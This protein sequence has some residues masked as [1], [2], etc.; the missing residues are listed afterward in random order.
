MAEAHVKYATASDGVGIA[1]ADTGG[2][3]TPVLYMRGSPFTHV[4]L[5][6][7][8]TSYGFWFENLFPRRRLITFDCRGCGL[9][10]RNVEEMSVEVFCR[11]IAAVADKLGLE[12]FALIA[13]YS[14]GIAATAYAA[15]NP[16]RVSHLILWDAYADGGRFAEIPQ[17]KA[18]LSMMENDWNLFATT[19]G[20]FMNDWDS[21]AAREYVEFLQEASTQKEALAFFQNYV[22]KSDTSDDLSRITQPALVLSHKNIEI[23]DFDMARSLASS[24]PNAEL[25]VLEG[26]WGKPGED[27]PLVEDALNRLLGD[28]PAATETE[29]AAPAIGS[30]VTILFTDIEGSTALTQKL[31]DAGARELFR[32]HERITREAL[33]AHGGAEVKTMGDGFM[34]SFGSAAGA[35]ECAIAIQQALADGQVKVRI[36][37]NAGEPIAEENPDGRGDLFGTSVI[38]AA[39]IAAQASGGEILASNVVRELVAGRLPL[40][41]QG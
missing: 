13:A 41:G 15:D 14:D 34:V 29:P 7:K 5:E 18:F 24:L 33:A 1:F 8:Q 17:T 21:D 27:P 40:L 36:G 9:S 39:R 6:W 35:I 38:L 12:R 2:D 30:L 31:G 19:L 26:T 32:E 4:Q 10:D 28:A 16:E 3:G 25:V 37:I 22:M 11:D 23:P 20:H